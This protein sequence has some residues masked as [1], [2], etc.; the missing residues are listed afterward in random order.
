[1]SETRSASTSAPTSES[2]I[3]PKHR[4]V[5]REEWLAARRELLAKEKELTRQRDALARERRALPWVRVGRSYVFDGLNGKE[6]LTDL[7]AGRSQLLIYHFMYPPS[8]EAG[9]KSCSFWADG[10]A[11]SIVHLAHRDVTMAVVSIAPIEQ[12]EAFRR[13]MGWSFKWVSSSANSFNRDFGV[14]FE[15]EEIASGR[16]IYNYGTMPFGVEEAPGVSV[17]ANSGG[18]VFHTYSCYARGLDA[19]NPAYQHLDLVPKGRDEEGLPHPMAWVR[20]HD[21]YGD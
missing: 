16:P 1:M 12:I 11:G 4:V 14:S 21:A 7:F 6:S 13:R 5:S 3:E 2:T 17:F 19:L 20:H 9:C 8:W 10:F 15:P 18:E